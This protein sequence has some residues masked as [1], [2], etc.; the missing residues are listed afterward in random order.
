MNASPVPLS[1][2][3]EISSK[4]SEKAKFPK[5]PKIVIPAIILVTVSNVVTISTSLFIE[6]QKY[7]HIY[8]HN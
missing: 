1:T 7:I 5:M 4:P 3:L 6:E 8:H 2:T